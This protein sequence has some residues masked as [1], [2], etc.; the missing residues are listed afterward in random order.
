[1]SSQYNASLLQQEDHCIP[2][3]PSD[4]SL[5]RCRAPPP[6][7][8][9]SP[10]R[11]STLRQTMSPQQPNHTVTQRNTTSWP[12][13]RSC[14]IWCNPINPLCGPCQNGIKRCVWPDDAYWRSCSSPSYAMLTVDEQLAK[15]AKKLSESPN[16]AFEEFTRNRTPS[17]DSPP[18]HQ[19]FS[20]DADA[21]TLT[22]SDSLSPTPSDADT[23]H[24]EVLSK[25]SNIPP[26]FVFK[27]GESGDSLTWS[28]RISEISP[29]TSPTLSE[30]SLNSTIP[31]FP[32]RCHT[33]SQHSKVSEPPP[34]LKSCHISPP[35]STTS[36]TEVIT[37]P[38]VHG[39]RI[40]LPIG[41]DSSID[42]R[43]R[44]SSISSINVAFRPVLPDSAPASAP[45]KTTNAKSGPKH[46]H[47]AKPQKVE[48]GKA[49]G[50]DP[51]SRFSDDE[52]DNACK[53]LGRIFGNC[54]T[55]RKT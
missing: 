32:S 51:T 10:Q 42:T 27:E 15:H 22:A 29:P 11:I 54:F 34:P 20:A 39:K 17:V 3:P 14:G 47:R 33:A 6:S 36:L 53:S 7:P 35:F 1:M 52:D 38:R 30:S 2:F 19:R 46:H 16:P 25:R 21:A 50:V 9:L 24:D 40:S 49:A 13:C 55:G 12:T 8:T 26:D 37:M 18:L 45:A 28:Q 41:S 5:N 23:L 4:R 48:K 43:I 44:P 31:L